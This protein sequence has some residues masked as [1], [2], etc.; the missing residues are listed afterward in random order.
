[1]SGQ[2]I[3]YLGYGLCGLSAILLILTEVIFRN[4][5]KKVIRKVYDELG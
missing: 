5:K 3:E 1:M 4:R 2:M